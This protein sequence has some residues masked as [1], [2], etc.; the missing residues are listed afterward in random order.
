MESLGRP[1]AEHPQ[2]EEPALRQADRAIA[3][4]IEYHAHIRLRRVAA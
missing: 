3:E 4:T 1:L 2:A